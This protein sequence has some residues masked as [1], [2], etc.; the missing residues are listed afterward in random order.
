MEKARA[1][2]K[3]LGYT[4]RDA[5]S[6][7]NCRYHPF[8]SVC[9]MDEIVKDKAATPESYAILAVGSQVGPDRTTFYPLIW[10][11]APWGATHATEI[12]VVGFDRL[13]DGPEFD[14]N[15][16]L[17][18]QKGMGIV[19]VKMA[20]VRYKQW[21]T[22]YNKRPWEYKFEGRDDWVPEHAVTKGVWNIK[23]EEEQAEE[24]DGE[25]FD[26]NAYDL[27]CAPPDVFK[28]MKP[29]MRPM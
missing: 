27:A 1:A 28:R 16:D 21:D 9:M 17:H 18:M 10:A 20:E 22:L 6:Q 26:A 5:N 14:C 2:L 19:H 29:Y 3:A 24:P 15:K 13:V 12:Q 11:V 7:W 8:D 4:I 25:W 23:T